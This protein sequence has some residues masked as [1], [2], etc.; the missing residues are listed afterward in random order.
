MWRASWPSGIDLGWASTI[1]V[2]GNAFK[3]S[4]ANDRLLLDFTHHKVQALVSFYVSFVA[5]QSWSPD[6]PKIFW[7]RFGKFL[8][9]LT[10]EC[11]IDVPRNTHVQTRIFRAANPS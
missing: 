11:L 10:S 4:L 8:I 5:K 3:D 6:R 2:S 7:R 1:V 9:G